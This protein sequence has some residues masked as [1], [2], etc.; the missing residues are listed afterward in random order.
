[1]ST[2]IRISEETKAKLEAVR[3]ENESFDDLLSRLVVDRSE[4]DID[5]LLEMGEAGV[6]EHMRQQNQELSATLDSSP[7][8]GQS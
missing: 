8:E 4:G 6:G 1:M 3:R 5:D 2:S 7:D